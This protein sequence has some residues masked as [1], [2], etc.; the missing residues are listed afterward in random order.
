LPSSSI[1]YIANPESYTLLFPGENLFGHGGAFDLTGKN[2][3]V[4]P[5]KAL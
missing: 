5:L 4:R 3:I 1:R 2:T